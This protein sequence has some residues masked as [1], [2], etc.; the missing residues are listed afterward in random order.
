[1]IKI[2]LEES[3]TLP[4]NKDLVAVLTGMYKKSFLKL[5]E[6]YILDEM[7]DAGAREKGF[8]SDLLDLF[9]KEF[10]EIKDLST[11]LN[12]KYLYNLINNMGDDD[13]TQRG[14]QITRIPIEYIMNMLKQDQDNPLKSFLKK[15]KITLKA[16]AEKVRQYFEDRGVEHLGI[17]IE[18][19]KTSDKR[20]RE[21]ET[22]A[23][24]Y[25][26]DMRVIA[27]TFEA[28][29]FTGSIV[30]NRDGRR[31]RISSRL[32]AGSGKRPETIVGYL[33][34]ELRELPISIRHEL[35]HFYQSL[36]S[37][38]FGKNDFTVGLPPQQVLKR[39]AKQAGDSSSHHMIPIEMQTDI[40]DEVDKFHME[41]NKFRED[42]ADL[43]AK[44]PQV[45]KNAVKIIIKVMT[46]MELSP[47]EKKFSRLHSLDK[48]TIELGDTLRQI[49]S[50]DKSGK[51]YNYALRVLY[52]SVR[53]DVEEIDKLTIP[54]SQRYGRGLQENFI[55]DKIKVILSES[56]QLLSEEMTKEELRRVIRDEF[57]KLLK[58]KENRKEIA[59]ITKEFVKKFYRELSF[60]STHI[61]D[62]V[63]V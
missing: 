61:I 52:S 4:V 59:K 62:Q 5:A 35:Q 41:L 39:S 40:Q 45:L 63:D 17:N 47:S 54:I 24:L 16:A 22:Y 25:I 34:D 6:I 15:K 48:Y 28:S 9:Y 3:R 19:Q 21:E 37:K 56:K 23:G 36:F 51:L 30:T 18:L 57:E 55:M 7:K 53:G 43:I 32:S 50:D 44:E 38:I 46:D 11:P 58:D 13:K 1:M 27:I 29:F 8:Y 14:I 33:K 26:A 31:I 60:S 10:P 49:K 2:K 12:K 20:D 42:K